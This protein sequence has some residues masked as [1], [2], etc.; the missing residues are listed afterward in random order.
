MTDRAASSATQE[1]QT[2]EQLRKLLF[3]V[4]PV[5]VSEQPW[6]QDGW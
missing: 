1:N 6:N 3:L 5:A 2:V 4:T